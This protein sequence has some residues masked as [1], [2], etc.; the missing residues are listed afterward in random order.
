MSQTDRSPDR[1]LSLLRPFGALWFAAV[2]LLL[3]SV[4]MGCATL[5]ESSH[6]TGKALAVFYTSW[7]FEGLLGLLALNITT[8]MIVRY[9]FS[10]RQIGFVATHCSIL[11]VLGGA[12]LTQRVG[13]DGR[14]SIVEGQS[15]E[16]FVIPRDT[17]TLRSRSSWS[18]VEFDPP[19]TTGTEPIE[20]PGRPSVVHDKTRAEILRFA[21][22]SVVTDEMVNDNPH[23]HLALEV[24][25]SPSGTEDPAWIEVKEPRQIG[26]VQV[27]CRQVDDEKELTRLAT[28][29]PA[30]Q[31]SSKGV[32]RITYQGNS[33]DLPIDNCIAATQPVGQTGMGLRVLRYMPH[34]I[35]SE[36]KLQNASDKPVNPA[37]Q[38]ELSG[39]QGVETRLA[40]ARVPEFDSMHG[41]A[42]NSD[43]KLVFV[44]AAQTEVF[45]PVE[46]L[47]GP[48]DA[49]NVRFSAGQE[50]LFQ[51]VQSGV[52]IDTPWPGR[53]LGILRIFK[54]ARPR[55]SVAPSLNLH[56]EQ[57][58]AILVKLTSGQESTEIWVQKHASQPTV[59]AGQTYALDYGDKSM[60]LGFKVALDSFRVGTYP[61]T[62]RPRSFESHITITDPSS[63]RQESRVIS[64]NRPTSF[65]GYTFYQSSYQ[66]E[67]KH[68]SSVL[69][70]SSDPGQPVVFA[71]YFLL[72]GGMLLVLINRLRDKV[73]PGSENKGE[74]R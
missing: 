48:G 65:G 33:Y 37:I 73:G 32:A 18:A 12:L 64:M 52:P 47:V 5:F 49:L 63:G 17:L 1:M 71:G 57:T 14:V 28:T 29:I 24:S 38:A 36:G 72:M 35:V 39:P 26:E 34:A 51:K 21:P 15:A 58:P 11:L 20:I 70:V 44:A 27:A 69:S 68:M 31:P 10:R 42:K 43:V 2:L 55:H 6:G 59:L 8:A 13:I 60:P 56:V 74:D 4:A 50:L 16:Q 23:D 46:I 3:I 40:F 61:G 19:V 66:R 7:W 9:P 30:T 67:G 62:S 54:N 45:A 53:K 25:F 41:K 22:D